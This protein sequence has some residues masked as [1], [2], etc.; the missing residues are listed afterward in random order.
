MRFG[1]LKSQFS[2]KYIKVLI[3]VLKVQRCQSAMG[4]NLYFNIFGWQLKFRISRMCTLMV[5]TW[6][7]WTPTPPTLK[8]LRQAVLRLIDHNL[9][10]VRS[11]SSFPSPTHFGKGG[12]GGKYRQLM[13]GKDSLPTRVKSE[14]SYLKWDREDFGH[15]RFGSHQMMR[16]VQ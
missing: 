6:F 11:P 1:G 7:S 2:A 16:Y 15:K 10:Q 14:L 13:F 4:W 5:W 8:L 9:C 3:L 12:K